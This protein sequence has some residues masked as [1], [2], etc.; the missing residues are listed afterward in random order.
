[1]ICV[2]G[3]QDQGYSQGRGR[4]VTGLEYKWFLGCWKCS[5]L[6]WVLVTFMCLVVKMYQNVRKIY[7]QIIPKIKKLI[8]TQEDSGKNIGVWNSMNC[9]K[10]WVCHIFVVWS[11]V[12][13]RNS[14]CLNFSLWNNVILL[15]F[16]ILVIIYCKN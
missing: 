6:I 9:F 13:Y 4:I 11:W 3:I 5:V 12:S 15:I 16:L 7:K 2:V 10:S 14:L 1:M 8:Y